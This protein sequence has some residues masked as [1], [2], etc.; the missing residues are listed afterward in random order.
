MHYPF[1]VWQNKKLKNVDPEDVMCL[2]TEGNYTKIVLSDKSFFLVRSSLSTALKKL[3]PKM[4]IQTHRSFAAS[5]FF[6]DNVAR[7]HLTIGG[8]AIPIGKQYYSAVIKQ[9][10]VID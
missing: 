2:A 3:P 1:F 4:F 6:I 5:I 8:E 10:N 9:L 7:D